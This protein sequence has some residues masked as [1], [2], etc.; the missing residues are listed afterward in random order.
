MAGTEMSE[1]GK[2]GGKTYRMDVPSEVVEA[3][4]LEIGV[5]S[6][7]AG[8]DSSCE[9]HVKTCEAG[10]D[11]AC[12]TPMEDVEALRGR[13]SAGKDEFVARKIVLGA[14]KMDAR[15]QYYWLLFPA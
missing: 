5:K 9:A 1:V 11:S 12:Q 2:V 10:T 15:N 14:E 4:V 13:L 3:A 6:C 8:T 7:V